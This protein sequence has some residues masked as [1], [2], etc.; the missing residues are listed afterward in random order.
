MDRFWD[1]TDSGVL[2]P[3]SLDFVLAGRKQQG[4]F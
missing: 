4:T 2:I 3:N 1:T